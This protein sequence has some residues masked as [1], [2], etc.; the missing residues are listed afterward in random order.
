[1]HDILGIAGSPALAGMDPSWCA[2]QTAREWLPR[3]RGDGPRVSRISGT[4]RGAPPRSRGWT[5]QRARRARRRRG[6]PALAGMDPIRASGPSGACRLPRARGD[7][8]GASSIRRGMTTAPPRSRGWTR[9]VEEVTHAVDGSPAL[10]GMDP[11]SMRRQAAASDGSPALAGMDP[12]CPRSSTHRQAPPRS[13]GWTPPR[14]QRCAWAAGSPA[15]AGMDP[16]RRRRRHARARLPRARGDGPARTSSGLAF[17][18]APPRSRGWTQRGAVL[19]ALLAWLP[20]ARGDGPTRRRASS[21]DAGSPALAG[22]DPVPLLPGLDSAAA[23]PRSRGWTRCGVALEPARRAPPRSRG[24]TRRRSR[25]PAVVAG[26]PA[27]AGMDPRVAPHVDALLRLPRARGDGP[28]ARAS[29]TPMYVGSPALA[30]MDPATAVASAAPSGLPRARGDGPRRRPA[31]RAVCWAPPRSR[32]WTPGWHD[33]ELRARGSPALAGM[34]PHWRSRRSCWHRLPRARGDGPY[35]GGPYE[36][37][38]LG[39]PALAGMDP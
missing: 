38:L 5:H 11:G 27:L 12:R 14:R 34:D 19:R 39:S 3:A 37:D 24:W 23:P 2:R 22:M 29:S 20:R 15:L 25:R 21:R 35:E 8:P 31:S 7:G 10:A 9:L 6:S 33:C 13:R 28:A 16:R 30:G 32:G 18:M 1:M 26:S 36:G 17:A 4:A